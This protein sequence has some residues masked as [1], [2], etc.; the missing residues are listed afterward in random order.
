MKNY[1]KIFHGEV[2]TLDIKDIKKVPKTN[3]AIDSPTGHFIAAAVQEPEPSADADSNAEMHGSESE[4]SDV[5]RT[6]DGRHVDP[7]SADEEFADGRMHPC[8]KCGSMTLG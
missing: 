7:P 5:T 4:E 3:A 6:D 1:N 8:M 2:P